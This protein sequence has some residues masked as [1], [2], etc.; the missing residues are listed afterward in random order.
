[1]AAIQDTGIH[2]G[3]GD[4]PEDQNAIANRRRTVKPALQGH[5]RLSN[6]GR[7][8][9]APLF[10]CHSDGIEFAHVRGGSSYRSH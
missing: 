10:P 1:M 4:L 8:D 7:R 5:R 2:C 9:R 6:P 3:M